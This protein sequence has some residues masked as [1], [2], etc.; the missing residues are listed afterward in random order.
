[1]T[2]HLEIMEFGGVIKV[3]PRTGHE[4]PERNRRTALLLL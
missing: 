2:F 1:M 4:G 3:H